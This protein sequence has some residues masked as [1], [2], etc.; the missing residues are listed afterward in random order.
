MACWGYGAAPR[1][2]SR[3]EFA[4]ARLYTASSPQSSTDASYAVPYR[5]VPGVALYFTALK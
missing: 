5:N 4:E 1:Q 2:L 3:G